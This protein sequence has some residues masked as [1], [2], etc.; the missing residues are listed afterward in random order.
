[1]RRN[2]IER[3]AAWLLCGPVGHFAGGLTDVVELAARYWWSRL[4]SGRAR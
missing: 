4:R 3:L 1:M 2:P